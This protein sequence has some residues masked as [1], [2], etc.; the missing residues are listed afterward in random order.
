[1]ALARALAADS[2]VLLLDEPLTGLDD[3]AK[4]RAIGII[5][6]HLPGKAVLWVTHD[7]DEKRLI[8][9]FNIVTL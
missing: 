4:A 1:V 6:E 8:P 2:D 7:K 5:E 9:S 3:D